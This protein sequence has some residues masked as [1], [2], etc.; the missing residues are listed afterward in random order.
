[1]RVPLSIGY[2]DTNNLSL[3]LTAGVDVPG[4]ARIDRVG[5]EIPRG[6]TVSLARDPDIVGAP[7]F[8]GRGGAVQPDGS[9]TLN[10]VGPGDYRVLVAPFITGFQWAPAVPPKGLENLYVK[11][12]R[13]DGQET[14]DEGFHLTSSAVS[15]P[16][17]IVLAN[18]GKVSGSVY[19]DKR[20]SLPNVT[21]AL[22][23][24]TPLRK[25]TDLYRTV[26]TDHLGRFQIQGVPP[27]AYKAFAWQTV[28]RDIWQ[29]PEFLQLI[30]SRGAF[31]DVRE[32]GDA[33]VDLEAIVAPRQ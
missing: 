3:A 11:S 32:G 13:F 10:A 25:R 5:G 33:T 16:I 30:E 18:G 15:G 9:F 19:N 7:A 4:K 26:G 28:E 1:V 21:V 24:D 14:L 12:A 23:P 29:T 8:Q 6:L 20:E 2:A 17:E 31:V 27:G 22:V